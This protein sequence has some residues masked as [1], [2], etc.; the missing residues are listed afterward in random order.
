MLFPTLIAGGFSLLMT[1]SGQL[2]TDHLTASAA[3]PQAQPEAVATVN[4]APVVAVP[5]PAGASVDDRDQL[6]APPRQP[7]AS[8]VDR[9]E[10]SPRVPIP[11]DG[12]EQ[13]LWRFAIAGHD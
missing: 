7:A 9:I 5:S 12:T 13:E 10:S 1:S 2:T 4:I 11:A 6:P 8:I 3:Q